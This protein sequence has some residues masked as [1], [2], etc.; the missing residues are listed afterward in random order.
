MSDPHLARRVLVIGLD[1]ATFNIIEPLVAQGRLPTLGRLMRE[2][3]HAALRSTVQ[4]SSEQA[5]ASFMTGVQNGKHGVF[6]FVRRR[7]GS[8]EF[9]YVSGRDV[10]APALWQILSTRGRP[11]ITINVPMTYPPQPVNGVLIGGL[12]SPG[13]RSRF[14]YPDGMYDELSR[15]VGGYII[16]VDIERGDLTPEEEERLVGQVHEMIRLRTAATLYLA[17]TRPWD[18]LTVVYAAPDRVSH[19]FWKYMDPTHPLYTPEGAAR[20]GQVIPR[21][22]EAVDAAV[23]ELLAALADE[24]T[25]V[26]ILSDHGFGPLHKAL[27]LNKWLTQRGYLAYRPPAPSPGGRARAA[28]TATARRALRWLDLPLLSWLKARAFELW[29]GLKGELFSSMTFAQVDWPRTRAY[30]VGTMGNIYL[31]VQGREP[32]GI[33]APEAEYEQ[34]RD[35]LINELA[36]LTDDETG[37][38]VFRAVY[39]REELYDG[40]YLQ[41]APDIVCLKDARYH[42]AAVDWRTQRDDRV[43]VPLQPGELLFAADISAQHELDGILIAWGAGVRQ[44]GSQGLPSPLPQAVRASRYGGQAGS[45]QPAGPRIIDLAPTILR[46]LGEPVPAEMDGVPLLGDLEARERRGAAFSPSCSAKEGGEEG[47]GYTEEEEA[48][49]KARLRSLGYLD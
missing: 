13:E 14:T 6:S 36:A 10:R 42:V 15:A 26:L 22:Y 2:G 21:V 9:G 29:P 40:P 34:V 18:L 7:P 28:F 31:N 49:L 48:E 44:G 19:K 47:V 32:A 41:E 20:F 46:L 4:P 37:E 38:P 17:R 39:R 33:V 45:P 25:T 5:W 23:A 12:M 43:L 1:G 27:Y 24:Q 8:Y 16:D 30:A 11:T 35:S 3:V